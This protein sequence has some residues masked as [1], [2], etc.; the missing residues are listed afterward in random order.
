MCWPRWRVWKVLDMS[1]LVIFIV[2]LRALLILLLSL[3]LIDQHS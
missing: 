1:R 3:F 2:S